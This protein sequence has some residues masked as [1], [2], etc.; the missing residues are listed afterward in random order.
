MPAW[1]GF[2]N[3]TY[4]GGY[5]PLGSDNVYRQLALTLHGYDNRLRVNRIIKQLV[6]GNLGGTAFGQRVRVAGHNPKD[7]LSLSGKRNTELITVINRP[8]VTADQVKINKAL[9]FVYGPQTWP[10]DKSGNGGGGKRGY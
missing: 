9:D 2:W 7:N 3:H 8:T 10:R 4:G 6:N 1:S 5:T